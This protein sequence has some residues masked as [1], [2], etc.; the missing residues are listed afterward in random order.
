MKS[1]FNL[2]FRVI[3]RNKL[4]SFLNIAG[5]AVGM[6]S[7]IIIV[8]WIVDEL[9]YD[10]F[11]DNADRIV[12][13]TSYFQM[14]GT[15]GYGSTCPAPLAEAAIRDYP[16]VENAVRLRSYGGF[17]VEYDD[18]VFNEPNFIY[19]DSTFF[20]VFSFP[21]LEGDPD[22]VLKVRNTVA[23]SERAAK[24][25]F[26]NEEALGK[27]LLLDNRTEVEVTGVFENMPA[28]SHFHFDFIVS[29]H[30]NDEANNGQWLSN[31]FFTYLLLSPNVSV[32]EFEPKLE[33]L[34][35]K[36]ISEEAAKALG[37]SWQEI[38]ESGT[39]LSYSLIKLTDIH[40][41]SNLDYEL[42][43]GGNMNAV[44]IFG[45]IALFI[46]LVY[47][48]AT[49]AVSFGKNLSDHITPLIYFLVLFPVVVFIGFLWLVS[50]HH[51]KIYGPSDFK[52]EDNF[53]K[54]KMST[55]ASLTAETARQKGDTTEEEIQEQK[56]KIL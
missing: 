9:S 17:I 49:I 21:L 2:L 31:N 47:G 19:A 33:S 54:M 35:D 48:F 34:I 11:Q 3:K 52:N 8:L 18:K 29:A 12:R 20:K 37:M 40:L 25:Y 1:F 23:I 51:D 14:N 46:V 15:E 53:L 56:Q 55:V 27:I 41:K 30:S 32:E 7:F 13:V 45:I 6:A 4:F 24:K 42:E 10:K 39:S 5:L 36:Y 26:G 50:K 22:E 44:R 43:A 16:E 38:K 28:A